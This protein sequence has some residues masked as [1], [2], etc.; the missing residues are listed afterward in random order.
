MCN[1]KSKFKFSKNFEVL[2]KK[3][4]LKFEF[5]PVHISVTIHCRIAGVFCSVS[6][7]IPIVQRLGHFFKMLDF[8]SFFLAIFAILVSKIVLFLILSLMQNS[9]HLIANFRPA[10]A[11][12]Y[13]TVGIRCNRYV[14]TLPKFTY[15]SLVSK[16]QIAFDYFYSLCRCFARMSSLLVVI[17]Q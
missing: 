11:N 4:L 7:D 9:I 16:P 12:N 13:S 10:F 15:S 2:A 17:L 8:G 6:K 3:T 1:K 14:I 5:C